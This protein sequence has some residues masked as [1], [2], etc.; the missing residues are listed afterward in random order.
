MP[1]ATATPAVP[2]VGV[3]ERDVDRHVARSVVWQAAKVAVQITQYIV[4][5]RLVL[6]AEYG[7][8]ALALPVLALLT[9]LND[10]GLSTA[11]VTN[12]D[13]D[14]RL[15][16]DLYVTQLV[17]GAGMALL[18]VLL[19]PILSL[20]YHV[21][22][23]QVIG[24]WL[25]LCLVA[26][27]WG[28]QPRARLRREL[29]IGALAMVDIAGVIAG[30]LVALLTA[31]H[32]SGV[33]V[34]VAAQ[35][36]NV[37]VSA[38][39]AMRLAPV[40]LHRFRG[41]RTYRHALEIG[42]HMVGSDVLN[43]V[44]NQ[45]P[46][47]A[48]GLFVVLRDVGLFNRA[49]QLLNLPLLVLAPAL[50]NFLLPLLSRSRT[51]PVEFRRHVRRTLR[52]FLAASIPASVWIAL[53]PA[54]LLALV[55]GEEWRPVMPIL[56]GLSPL[57]VVQIVAVVA[58]ITLVGSERSRVVRRFAFWNLG[59]TIAAVLLT[60]PF[61]VLAMAIG[62]SAS[63]LLVRAP[64]VVRYALRERTLLL[65]DVSEALRFLL[66]LAAAAGAA[67]GLCRLLPLPP[68]VT[69]IM[70]LGIAALISGA[71]LFQT[72]RGGAREVAA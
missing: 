32:Y 45:F 68:V 47:L 71:V 28:L 5:A 56:V 4:L 35:I 65:A 30:L 34:L 14:E 69:E 29:R 19:A 51:H 70:G 33:T 7:K 64:L 13:Y 40:R 52:L 59:V 63:G 8:F 3:A 67:L 39:V 60:A 12:S 17:L 37:S 43:S 42:W 25:A 31:R 66:M 57:F 46:A 16:S 61:G 18:M 44:R 72:V 49:F 10:G 58:M 20:V 21:A 15:A 6:P 23:L 62:L 50:T 1:S 41:Q 36:A 9:A 27:A 2:P 55:L 22:D 53:G 24:W 48:I 26:K 11:A 54:D 38:V